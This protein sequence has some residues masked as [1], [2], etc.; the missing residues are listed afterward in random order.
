MCQGTSKELT[1][2]QEAR[3]RRAIDKGYMKY[4]PASHRYIL[5]AVSIAARARTAIQGMQCSYDLEQ[6]RG[7][8]FNNSRDTVRDLQSDV[9]VPESEVLAARSIFQAANAAKHA[10]WLAK[11]TTAEGTVVAAAGSVLNVVASRD[12]SSIGLGPYAGVVHAASTR[13]LE[14]V[15]ADGAGHSTCSFCQ[16]HWPGW[17]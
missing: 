3:K 2:A 17:R 9:L 4:R 8:H 16:P 10:S 12:N 7:T 5:V 14:G 13:Q 1:L 15:F 11:D 6:Q